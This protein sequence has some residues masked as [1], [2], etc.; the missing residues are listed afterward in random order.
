M[1]RP[2][3]RSGGQGGYGTGAENAAMTTVVNGQ[4]LSVTSGQTS[5]GVIV[6]FGGLLKVLFGGTISS[7]IDSGSVD[8]SS[9]G[10]AVATTVAEIFEVF[11]GGRSIATTIVSGGNEQVMGGVD[12]LTTISSGGFAF[13]NSG[14]TAIG[15]K[16][17]GLQHLGGK[18]VG[19]TI[20]SGGQQVVFGVFGAGLAVSALV[21]SGGTE[22]VSS[23]GHASAVIVS[24]GGVQEIDSGGVA[25]SAR[26]G[27][28]AG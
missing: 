17:E 18:A 15:T 28:G 26:I 1:L 3:R 19:G 27:G 2:D 9:G 7:T 12:S 21:S 6:D 11:S 4:T 24:S 23:G 25:V 8:V 13:V 10:K 22:I 5:T 14:A 20:F 16:I